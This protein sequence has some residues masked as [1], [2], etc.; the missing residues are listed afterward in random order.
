LVKASK[1]Q[2]EEVR[3]YYKLSPEKPSTKL[4]SVVVELPKEYKFLNPNDNSFDARHARAYLSSRGINQMDIDKYNIGYCS[5]GQYRNRVIVPS[6]DSDGKLNY[7]I[8]RSINPDSSY[9]ID[10]PICDKTSIIGFEHFIN[11]NVPIILCEGVFDAIAIKRNAIPLFGKSITEALMVRITK[12]DVKTV[13][14]ALDDDA[15]R[16]SIEYA[17][18]LLNLGKEVYLISLDGKDPSEIGF[19]R[20]IK[21]LQTATPLTFK[22][23]LK[24]R[25][26]L[27]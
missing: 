22:D 18:K 26:E 24:Y 21:N 19:D 3:E 13:Y 25:M 23:V 16:A 6:Y 14:L 15:I 5:T 20:M 17:E 7:F 10:A 9:K 4:D 2:V 8:A 11:W 27:S 1:E 12:P